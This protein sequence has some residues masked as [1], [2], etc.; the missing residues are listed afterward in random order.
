MKA[1][2]IKGEKQ[3]W[4]GEEE[5]EGGSRELVCQVTKAQRSPE[6]KGDPNSCN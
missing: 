3:G 1:A 2:R 5:E 4:A 6:I